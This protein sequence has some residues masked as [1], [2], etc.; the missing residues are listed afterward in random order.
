MLVF[1]TQEQEPREVEVI[2][3]LTDLLKLLEQLYAWDY[4]HKIEVLSQSGPVS[5]V[6]RASDF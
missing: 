5:S 4:I 2:H 6:G 1:L 3:T